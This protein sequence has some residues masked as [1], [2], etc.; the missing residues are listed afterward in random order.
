MIVLLTDEDTKYLFQ[1]FCLSKENITTGDADLIVRFLCQT[2]FNDDNNDYELILQLKKNI[3]MNK[4]IETFLSQ[5]LNC[6]YPGYYN[7]S[8]MQMRKISEMSD[9]L[10]QTRLRVLS[11]RRQSYSVALNH[12]VNEIHAVCIKQENANKKDYDVNKVVKFLHSKTIPNEVCIKI[13]NMFDRRNS[14]SV[15]HP[16]SDNSIAWEVTH[17]EY[18]DY[19][20]H[21]GKCFDFLL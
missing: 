5:R 17:E 21:V 8:C 7:L 18:L 11:E 1:Q 19:Y 6:N 15:S 9:V 10:E 2:G 4:I 20:N 12:L 3:H 13:R 14:N 16:G